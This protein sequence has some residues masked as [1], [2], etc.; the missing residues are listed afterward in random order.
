MAFLVLNENRDYDAVIQ[1]ALEPFHERCEIFR[2]EREF[3][4]R[5]ADGNV[6]V[7][8]IVIYTESIDGLIVLEKVRRIEQLKSLPVV[9]ISAVKHPLPFLD[10]YERGADEY[11]TFPINETE[12][13]QK[14][15]KLINA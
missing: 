8:V 3:F 15:R 7:V 1:K 6:R 11:F 2:E 5:L 14:V 9:A 13:A 10:A 12:F 4:E